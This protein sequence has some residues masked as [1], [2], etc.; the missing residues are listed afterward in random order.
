MIDYIKK[1]I[2]IRNNLANHQESFSNNNDDISDETIVEYAHL[3]QELDDIS[4][5][6][7][8]S[9][10]QR[11]LAIDIPVE[12]D[13]EI[14]TIEFNLNDGRVT[15]VPMDVA[16]QESY[17]YMK[18]YNDFYQEASNKISQMLR[19][20]DEIYHRRVSKVADQ[21]YSEYCDTIRNKGLFG[22]N[23]IS[24]S[25]EDVPST[26]SVNI[27][28]NKPLFAKMKVFF[29]TDRNHRILKK[30]IDPVAIIQ[31]SNVIG[32]MG[33]HLSSKLNSD[34]IWDMITPSNIYVPQT[35]G[36]N[37]CVIVEFTNDITGESEYVGWNRTIKESHGIQN[38]H[39]EFDVTA[40]MENNNFENKI[41]YVHEYANKPKRLVSRF[42]QEAIDFGDEN[43]SSSTEED[44]DENQINTNDD[45]I[46]PS[47][48]D[49]EVSVS[50]DN[51]SN[52]D[53]EAKVDTNDVSKEIAKK[54][55]E[56]TN[57]DS[58]ISFDDEISDDN[59]SDNDSDN[60][61][62]SS[63]DESSSINDELNDLDDDDNGEIDEPSAS[64]EDLDFDNMTIDELIAQ[65]SEKLKGMTLQEIK[66]FIKSPDSSVQEA[67]IL[68]KKNINKVVDVQIRK[69]LGIL[70]DDKMDAKQI[71]KKF[72]SE[73]KK[74]NRT[75]SRAMKMKEVY[76]TDE[77][78]EFV[79]L[80]RALITFMT[81]I[82]SSGN[83]DS[84]NI[85]ENAKVFNTQCG[86]VA[87]IV[88]K[89][90]KSSDEP[91]N[92]TGSMDNSKKSEK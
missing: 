59:S 61:E 27:G 35:S 16:V 63:S 47:S 15:D 90:L 56:K 25:N 76:S 77:I 44:T 7:S 58:E 41:T 86:V 5:E 67:F 52:A 74:L 88:E 53:D 80:N 87:K 36:D 21:M 51:E 50:T 2:A 43:E 1:Q 4:V 37:Y 33:E 22:H 39:N 68:T 11:S 45:E 91:M 46:P 9:G 18:T 73:G 75:L 26:V 13:I 69:T 79:K 42:Y 60:H 30:Q 28:T 14:D 72:K 29:E 49:E 24:I 17:K 32:R 81:S 62:E 38:S 57:E 10:K 6:G 84:E 40:F 3:F 12:D 78:L 55:K 82:K 89:K 65:G 85:K 23:K 70:N 66:D 83:Q 48:D 34:N 71:L 19:E 64:I 20:D 54:V 92:D 8:E 31:E